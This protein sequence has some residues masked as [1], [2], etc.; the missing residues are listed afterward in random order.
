MKRL[1]CGT[2]K[3]KQLL[4]VFIF[5][6][7]SG[8]LSAQTITI[9]TGGE[10][11]TSGTNW[12]TSGTNPV[13]I[14]AS[15]DA[16]INTSVVQDYLNSGVSVIINATTDIRLSNAI[17][18]TKGTASLTFQAGRDIFIQ[19]GIS[20]SGSSL[21]LTFNADSN[22]DNLGAIAV[23]D[24]LSTNGGAIT[25]EDDITFNGVAAQA[26]NS[27][28]A[29]I[30]FNGEVML[31]NTS[32]VTLTAS[33]Y[34]ISFKKAVN[35]GN[36]FALDA[37][38]RTWNDAYTAH[39]STNSYLATIT[40]RME[41][42]AAMAVVPSGGAWL[43]GSDQ[44]TE[45]TWKW[46]TGLEAGTIFWTTALSQGIKGYVGTNGSFVNWNTG[47]P[48]N[49]S[50]NEDA[51]QIRN[52]TD[53]FWNDLPATISTLASVVETQL[54]P[55]PLTINAG[56]GKV[57]FGG[58]V[59]ASNP[60]KT[61]TVT[62]ATTAI[63]GGSMTTNADGTHGGSGTQSYSGNITLGSA[64]TTLSMLDTPTDFTLNSGKTITNQ[65]GGD[66]ALT[67]KT[68][69]G[70]ITGANSIISSST[71]KLN[72][73]L[74][75]DTD[76]NGGGIFVNAG[77][78]ITSNGGDVTLSGGTDYTTGYARGTSATVWSGVRIDGSINSGTGSVL[79]R[80]Q[81]GDIPANQNTLS[82][83]G[84]FIVPSGSVTAT[85]GNITLA[86][87]VGTNVGSGNA[88]RAIRLGDGIASVG[89]ASITTTS[90]NISLTGT[91]APTY[92][93][94][95]ILFDSSKIQSG[96]GSITLTGQ[97]G[98]GE[99]DFLVNSGSDTQTVF[100][101]I[102]STS[103]NITVNANLLEVWGTGNLYSR[104][105][106]SGAGQLIIQPRTAGTT[107]GLAGGTGTLSLDANLFSTCFNNGYSNVT[108]GNAT[109]GNITI[110]GAV[111]YIDPL[112]LLAAGNIAINGNLTT[113]AS[114]TVVCKAGG[115]ITQA[116]SKSVT[117]NGGNVIYWADSDA[118][119][120]GAIS[121]G[122]ASSIA[123]SG[124]HLWMG[125]GS[126]STTWNG[127][128]VGDGFAQS[129]S[130]SAVV[131]VSPSISTGNGNISISGK[132]TSTSIDSYGIF[133]NGGT[134]TT[135][136]GNVSL[137]GTG[138]S[139]TSNPSNCDGIRLDGT[140]QTTTGNID[141][142]GVSNAQVQS[143]GI[144]I[145]SNGK[146]QST[147]GG[148]LS[149]KTDIIYLGGTG[150]QLQSTGTLTISPYNSTTTIGVAGATGMLTLP[151]TYFTSRIAD[152][153]S[154]ITIG[155][156]TQSGNINLNSVTFRDNMRLQT[157]G[158][159]GVN[160]GQTITATGIKLQIDNT[161]GMGAGSSIIR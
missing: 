36:S 91:T 18:K 71:G 160:A 75:A 137:N 10:T 32:G 21:P 13:T 139:S 126:G 127:L 70:I 68:T 155:G 113:T 104:F 157:T 80:G 128:T 17:S 43:G 69:A 85:S 106:L 56:A 28:A 51:L 105:S 121:M 47:E 42:A 110:G 27:G 64:S 150:I 63:N 26:I 142:A 50:G 131:L 133:V 54:S 57:T 67:I 114:A 41:L 115:D 19:A 108:I 37:T 120:G 40:S 7:I 39:S 161:L 8:Q 15:G 93:G 82:P 84:V 25:F 145:E 158:T 34:D 66:A 52:N 112:T 33:D 118:S 79:L 53:G 146:A 130:S 96:S 3:L 129:A 6:S 148:A 76:A 122:S 97:R 134:L 2:I 95:G 123:T 94:A 78:S 58:A 73:I 125:G 152:G 12:S 59:G 38:A 92:A 103:G 151:A 138:G 5:L 44:E 20:S 159:V 99:P 62:A 14:S 153:F 89:Q 101:Q 154:Q 109:A 111:S 132:S 102:I 81:I 90:G 24:N 22:D 72:T 1:I 119:G 48:N 16:T 86:G 124:G 55:S 140:L 100:N 11:G 144:A 149:L 30:A 60:L 135:T 65:S 107:I 147:S 116:A 35:S 88:L 31:S 77:A 87:Y 141:L 23:S 9:S 46:V 143:E 4:V 61:L 98:A 117:T 83:G 136:T 45:G 29:A 156:S 49:S 74:W